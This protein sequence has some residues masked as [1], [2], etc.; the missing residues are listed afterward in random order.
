[1]K[2]PM[3]PSPLPR[4][5]V[6]STL[7]F[8][9]GLGASSAVA[10]PRDELLRLVP[11]SMTFCVVVADVRERFKDIKDESF[12]NLISQTPFIKVQLDS[13][14]IQKLRQIQQKISKELKITPEQLRDEI[15]GD[16]VVFAYR[17]APGD[18]PDREQGL[19]LIWARDKVLAG[20]LVDRINEAQKKSG[21][22]KDLTPLKHEEQTYFKRTKVKADQTEEEF[23]LVRDHLIA[24][25]PKE[26]VIKAVIERSKL[27]VADADKSFWPGTMQRLGLGNALAAILVNPRAFDAELAS[28]ENLAKDEPKTFLKEFRRYWKAVDALGVYA[29]IRKDLE[30]GLALQVRKEELPAA[31]QKLFAELGQPSAVWKVIPED[32]LLAIA[33]RLNVAA[34]AEAYAGFCAPEKIQEIERSLEAGLRPFLPEKKKL[35]VIA[36]GIGPDWGF[37][38]TAPSS[39]DKKWAP[40]AMLALRLQNTPEGEA[41]E[42]TVRNALQFLVTIGQFSSKDPLRVETVK[43]GQIEIKSLAHTKFPSDVQPSFAVKDGFLLLTSSPAAI[44]GFNAPLAKAELEE[45]PLLRV[46]LSSWRN[47]LTGQRTEIAGFLAQMTGAD[48]KRIAEQIGEVGGNLKVFDRLEIVARS[49]A[50]QATIIVRL[51]TVRP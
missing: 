28:S 48:D 25:S 30:I 18:Q 1:M 49:K 24:F 16:A 39:T 46:S 14:E 35:N 26:A 32:A 12:L 47:Y 20:Q 9:I 38:V 15:L 22:L 42:T 2:N 44:R 23:Y 45:T 6:F 19:F 36:N 41:T 31:G 40:N 51:K 29:D 17:H 21:E 3:Y 37:W 8:G 13:P 4:F 50:D 34:F 5:F 11:E 10:A 27:A 43:D 7:F 33:S